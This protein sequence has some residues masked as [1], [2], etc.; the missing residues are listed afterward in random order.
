[1]KKKCEAAATLEEKDVEAVDPGY[2]V[3]GLG[4]RI[5]GFWV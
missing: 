3:L 1:M 2:R 4:F 5:Q